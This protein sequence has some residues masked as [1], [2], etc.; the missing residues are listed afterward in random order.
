MKTITAL[1]IIIISLSRMLNAQNV[2]LRADDIDSLFTV[3]SYTYVGHNEFTTHFRSPCFIP[4][5]GIKLDEASFD[6]TSGKLHLAGT[7]INENGKGFEIPYAKIMAGSISDTE[8]VFPD[9]FIGDDKIDYGKKKVIN[10]FFHPY[11]ILQ[12]GEGGEFDITIEVKDPKTFLT[13]LFPESAAGAINSADKVTGEPLTILSI[14]KMVNI[15]E[16]RN[17]G[18]FRK[19]VLK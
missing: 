1:S 19:S 13:F 12:A 6:T 2:G 14:V 8:S 5:V 17:P 3:H 16:I 7:V 9:I 11:Q 15:G 18:Y 10:T 4:W